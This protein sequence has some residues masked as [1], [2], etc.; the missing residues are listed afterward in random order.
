MNGPIDKGGFVYPSIVDESAGNTVERG[1]NRRDWYAG[2]AMQGLVTQM[3]GDKGTM[4]PVTALEVARSA[5][6][7]ADLMIRSSREEELVAAKI[8]PAAAAV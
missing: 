5:Y 2:L 6:H 4:R 3:G 7:I 8:G 1:I